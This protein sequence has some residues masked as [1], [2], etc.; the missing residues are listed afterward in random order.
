MKTIKDNLI[1][2]ELIVGA[3]EKINLF[4]DGYDYESFSKDAKTQSAV[5]M[6]F[7]IIGELS[8]RIPFEISSN[9]DLPWRQISGLRDIVSHDYFSLD[10]QTIWQTIIESVP[11][12][13]KKIKKY[14]KHN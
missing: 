5:I 2:L 10:I 9:I 13:D 6:Q 4:V 8:K 11:D 1:Y 3:I 7:Q 12:A 14:L